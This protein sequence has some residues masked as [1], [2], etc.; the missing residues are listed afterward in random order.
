MRKGINVRIPF[1]LLLL[2]MFSASVS[3]QDSVTVQ[4]VAGESGIQLKAFVDKTKLPFNRE[5]LFTIHLEW[6][7]DLDRYEIHHFDNPIIENFEIFGNTNSNRVV[8]ESGLRKAVQEYQYI[9]K[10]KSLGMGYIEGMV[11]QYTDLA[12]NEEFRLTTNRIE[13]E[14]LDPLPEPGSI[15]WYYITIPLLVLGALV[16]VFF[17]MDRRKKNRQAVNEVEEKISIEEQ[18]LRELAGSLDLDDPGLKVAEGIAFLSRLLRRFLRDKFQ[19]AGSVF[20]TDEVIRSLKALD[21]D[22]RFVNDVEEI[23]KRSDVIKFSGE[24]AEKS[25]LERF[26][27]LVEA[28]LQ[29]SRRGELN[30]FRENDKTE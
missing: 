8:S 26:Y 22:S 28:M 10:P 18:C 4:P 1:L 6:Y 19:I 15:K 13:V 29:K 30:G 14:I 3:S 16:L 25:E 24:S 12:S 11:I 7:G 20:L 5:M 2:Y 9:L 23:L 17:L 27:T 21:M